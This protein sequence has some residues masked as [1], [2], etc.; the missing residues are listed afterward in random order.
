[1]IKNIRF[2]DDMGDICDGQE[3]GLES[4]DLSKLVS[5]KTFDGLYCGFYREIVMLERDLVIKCFQC[6][7]QLK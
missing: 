2:L 3:S 1:M 4:T 6:W 5:M 7:E